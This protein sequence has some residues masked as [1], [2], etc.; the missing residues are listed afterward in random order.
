MLGRWFFNNIKL[1]VRN[2]KFKESEQ[3]LTFNNL[4]FEITNLQQI[5]QVKYLKLNEQHN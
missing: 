3:Q 5:N 4:K 1:L 2:L